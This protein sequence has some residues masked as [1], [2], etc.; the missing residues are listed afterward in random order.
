MKVKLGAGVEIDTLTQSELESS[1]AKHMAAWRE[2]NTLGGRFIPI[3]AKGTADG[4]GNLVIGNREGDRLGPSAG[5]YWDV[6]RLAVWGIDLT[7]KSATLYLG[8]EDSP[9]ARIANTA[10]SDSGLWTFDRQLVITDASSLVLT[11]T[12]LT[13]GDV[14]HLT[15]QAYEVPQSLGYLI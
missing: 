12:G 15:G 7:S 13:A 2:A 9:S 1:L 11:S 5:Y 4:T 3:R 8:S 10:M 14:V 6:R